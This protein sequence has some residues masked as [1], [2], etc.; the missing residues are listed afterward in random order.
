MINASVVAPAAAVSYGTFTVV[1][2]A[3]TFSLDTSATVA[4]A[5][6]SVVVAAAS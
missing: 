5:V 4:V 3:T 1:D 6:V 2:A